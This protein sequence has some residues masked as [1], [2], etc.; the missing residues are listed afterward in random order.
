MP[1]QLLAEVAGPYIAPGVTKIKKVVTFA[2]Y[3]TPTLAELTAG[4]VV[5]LGAQLADGSGWKL[6]GSDVAIPNLRSTFTASIPG[7]DTADASS[8]T[9]Y[10]DDDGEDIRAVYTKGANSY[11]VIGSG[12][13]GTGKFIDIFPVRVKTVS[14]DY[15][16]A[17]DANPLI[18]VEY[19]ITRPPAFDIAWP[20]S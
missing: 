1:E 15:K 9:F 5:E 8:L 14:K 16:L 17:G 7:R 18:V 4:T 2:N 6:S 3:L 12:G 20:A 10:A 13:T 11:T 19:T